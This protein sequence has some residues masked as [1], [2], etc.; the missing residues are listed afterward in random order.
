MKQ[1]ATGTIKVGKSKTKTFSY[2]L[3]LEETAS[4]EYIIAVIDADNTVAE[5]N[6]SNNY[7]VFGPIP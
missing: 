5:S 4:G 2:T 6:E 7:V 1:V 3:P